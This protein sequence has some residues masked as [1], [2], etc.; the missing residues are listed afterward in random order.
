MFV[1]AGAQLI[2]DQGPMTPFHP[3][4]LGPGDTVN[5]ALTERV[6]CDQITRMDARMPGSE[7]SGRSFT[8]SPVIVRYRVLGLTMS[9]TIS[10]AEPILV[11]QPVSACK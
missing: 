5:V 11:E 8:T 10:L 7:G 9:Q 2:T 1:P 6:I 3:V 4:A